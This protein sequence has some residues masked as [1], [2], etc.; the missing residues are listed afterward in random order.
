M[1]SH[2]DW[3]A[4]GYGSEGNCID[5]RFTVLDVQLLKTLVPES[6]Q[7]LMPVLGF[8]AVGQ[9]MISPSY[10][11]NIFDSFVF[12]VPLVLVM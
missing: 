7:I 4:G 12:M 5:S 2:Y 10:S 1:G 6:W 9:M 3:A 8:Q 11:D